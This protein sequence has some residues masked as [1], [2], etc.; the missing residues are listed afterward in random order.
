LADFLFRALLVV[1]VRGRT[2]E[3]EDLSFCIAQDQSLLE[4]PSICP[5]SAERPGFYREILS[6]AYSNP[7]GPQCCFAILGVNRRHPGIGTR[8]DEIESLTGEFEPNSIH[9]IRC[10]I[11]FQRPGGY[12]KVLQQ[13]NLELQFFVGFGKLSCSFR[14]PPIELTC[15]LF[16][17]IHEEYLLPPE[18]ASR[19]ARISGAGEF[20]KHK[21][22]A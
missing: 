21:C 19:T 15:I 16:L 4:M 10:P 18:V 2:D 8:P 9:E 3:F 6:R 7:K 13:P 11:R 17:L 12:R 14:D 20:P 1:D 5:V 22:L